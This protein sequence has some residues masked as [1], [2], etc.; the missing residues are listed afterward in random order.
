MVSPGLLGIKCA[1]FTQCNVSHVCSAS[2]KEMFPPGGNR[3]NSFDAP[4]VAQ[5]FS[6][7]ETV[8]HSNLVV[9]SFPMNT[10]LMFKGSD[11]PLTPENTATVRSD[12]LHTVCQRHEVI[13]LVRVGI[14]YRFNLKIISFVPWYDH[15][16]EKPL[17]VAR[18][19]TTRGVVLYVG[20]V[21]FSSGTHDINT[22]TT[23]SGAALTRR[24]ILICIQFVV[25]T[26]LQAFHMRLSYG[27]V[28][29]PSS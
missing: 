27:Q 14:H 20:P 29:I 23:R 12:S 16:E 24:Y 2:R 19:P 28:L 26:L 22:T 3:I 6:P 1:S 7:L 21:V 5:L 8:F 4:A 15:A 10:F 25:I 11:D 13:S 17:D 9:A 18:P